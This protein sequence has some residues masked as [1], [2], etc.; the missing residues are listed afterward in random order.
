MASET[1]VYTSPD[2]DTLDIRSSA[3]FV[4]GIDGRFSPPVTIITDKVPSSDGSRFRE[5]RFEDRILSI[6]W[7]VTEADRASVRS[8]LVTAARTFNQS[9]GL[10]VLRLTD[11]ASSS[12]DLSCILR[13]GLS[14]VDSDG[15]PL[16]QRV[17]LQFIAPDP[18]WY[19]TTAVSHSW[20]TGDEPGSF[21]PILPLVLSS[22]TVFAQP[23][24]LN[25]GDIKAWP[26]WTIAGPGSDFVVRNFTTGKTLSVNYTLGAQQTLE[27]DTRSGVKSVKVDGVSVFENA[28]GALWPLEPGDNSISVELN[29]STSDTVVGLSY[30]RGWIAA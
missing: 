24:I 17:V 14:G 9:K 4:Q 22:S 15:R 2:G 29:A 13:D 1:L 3:R 5:A 20:V 25:D 12:Y 19:D 23:T 28:T 18:F 7:A 8:F 16:L 6:P 27:I 30:R 21:F 11:E 26:V 10:G